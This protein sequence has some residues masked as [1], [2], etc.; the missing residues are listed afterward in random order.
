MIFDQNELDKLASRLR[1]FGG[2]LY[3]SG[4]V[5]IGE[6]MIRAAELIDLLSR[7]VT[8]VREQEEARKKESEAPIPGA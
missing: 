8:L 6:D 7:G 1:T 5:Q 4:L 3:G 2:G